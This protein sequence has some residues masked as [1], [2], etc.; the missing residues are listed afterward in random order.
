MLDS[1]LPRYRRLTATLRAAI[2]SGKYPVGSLLPTE[3]EISR[4]FGVSR[5]TVRDALRILNNAGLIERRRRAGTLVIKNTEPEEFV[6]PLPGFDE[7]LLYGRDIRLNLKTYDMPLACALAREF[8]LEADTW[9]RIDGKRG[10]DARLLGVTTAIIRRDCA[11]PKQALE[12]SDASLG[13]L[14]ERSSAGIVTRID[15]EISAVMTDR[16]AS[17]N[18]GVAVGSPALRA[19]RLYYQQP[20]KLFL[21]TESIHPADRFS[22]TLT[23]TRSSSDTVNVA[24]NN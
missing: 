1:N 12:N 7:V 23:F 19:R 4:S 3:L 2:M 15:Q 22:Y 21:I 6:Q 14:V 20:E 24:G 16:G 17:H 8:A 18:L 5:H 13:E 10:P 9:M 11:P